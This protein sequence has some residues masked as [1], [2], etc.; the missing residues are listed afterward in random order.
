VLGDEEFQDFGFFDPL[1]VI[2]R[3]KLCEIEIFCLKS[4]EFFKLS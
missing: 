4:C 2:A 3:W 1:S